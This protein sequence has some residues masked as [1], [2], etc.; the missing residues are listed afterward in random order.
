MRW[1]LIP[2]GILALAGCIQNNWTKPG[3]TEQDFRN[4]R[5]ACHQMYLARYGPYAAGVMGNGDIEQCLRDYGYRDL[6][7]V[8]MANDPRAHLTPEE[9][10]RI[11]SEID[12]K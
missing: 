4:D 6:A 1:M 8:Q 11:K 2:L 7:D 10:Q 9:I 5:Y 12:K 3:A